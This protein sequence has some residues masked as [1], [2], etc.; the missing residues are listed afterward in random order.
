M[1]RYA[2]PITRKDFYDWGGFSNPALY[3]KADG[4]GR[5]LYYKAV[6]R[7]EYHGTNQSPIHT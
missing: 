3:R 5:W 6:A 4:K 1:S 7:A 2:L